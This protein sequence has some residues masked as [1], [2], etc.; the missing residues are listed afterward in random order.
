M[1]PGW[2]LAT[3]ATP[4]ARDEGTFS[5]LLRSERS[6]DARAP[7]ASFSPPPA[8]RKTAMRTRPL[9]TVRLSP[10]STQN[11]GAGPHGIGVTFPITGGSFDGD[12]LHGKVLPGGDDWTVKRPDGV[13]ELNMRVTMET[14]DGALVYMT[15]DG[16]RDD[17]AP[18]A[19]YF[20]TLPR[21]ETGDPRYLFL[22]RLLA[23]GTGELRGDA[24]V[25]VIE[26]LL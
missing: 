26:E 14:H 24:A 4:A 10:A 11:V 8:D 25:H 17:E 1:R 16:I 12:R 18:G 19:P 20:R 23:V 21:F 15:F 5:S 22:N 6:L 9:I 3:L 2:A 13:I 7:V